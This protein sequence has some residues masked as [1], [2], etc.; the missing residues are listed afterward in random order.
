M[1]NT[2]RALI[3]IHQTA[4]VAVTPVTGG[5]NSMTDVGEGLEN[6][7][8]KA[9]AECLQ[10]QKK[11]LCK[12]AIEKAFSYTGGQNNPP[13]GMLQG[14]D[15]LEVK[16]SDSGAQIQLNSSFPKKKLT[17]NDSKINNKCREAEG[18]QWTSKDMV[19]IVGRV[20]DKILK[21]L[22]FVYGDCLA[23][24]DPIYQK[25]LDSIS[26][27]AA[28]YG[29]QVKETKEIARISNVGV[30]GNAHLRVRGMWLL[31]IAF[32]DI[33]P[34]DKTANLNVICLMR[35][36]KYEKFPEKDRQEIED[37]ANIKPNIEISDRKI[38]CPDNK[39]KKIDVKLIE[40]KL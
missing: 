7:V 37:I 18:G 39:G 16:K 32:K 33:Y 17:I 14:G 34:P 24:D 13:D 29:D 27:S 20:P 30:L 26:A 21:S 36:E 22:F 28:N 25:P 6:Y 9:Y 4:S 40:M 19:Y 31:D 23:A 5:S 10:E 3:H 15:A 1:T 38:D 2:L 12:K 11:A 35:K 8:K